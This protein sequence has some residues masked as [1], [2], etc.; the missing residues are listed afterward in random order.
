MNSIAKLLQQAKQTRKGLLVAKR[1]D[2]DP[3]GS[4]K[5]CF[6][7][8][9][10]LVTSAVFDGNGQHVLTASED[11]TARLWSVKSGAEL[12]RF[13]G[14]GSG[15]TNAV[16]D[17]NGQHVLTVSWDGTARLWS[18]ES[19]AELQRI[20]FESLVWGGLSLT[21]RQHVCFFRRSRATSHLC[22]QEW[23]EL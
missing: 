22:L 14:H 20:A 13:D 16:F 9:R 10:D 11:G 5:L 15:V 2:I 12:Q 18:V 4:Q 23:Q 19:G 1:Y 7:G 8:H 3:A 6:S 17:G 21:K